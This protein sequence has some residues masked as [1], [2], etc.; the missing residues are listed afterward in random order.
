MGVSVATCLLAYLSTSFVSGYELPEP[1]FTA[2]YSSGFEV[3]IPGTIF[4][5]FH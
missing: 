3:S 4:V 1:A 5:C 2:Y